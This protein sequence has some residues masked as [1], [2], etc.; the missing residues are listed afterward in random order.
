V[1]QQA[2]KEFR[3]YLVFYQPTESGIEVLRVIYGTRDIEAIWDD[4]EE[5]EQDLG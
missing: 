1:R 2:V 3:K 4:W 5:R